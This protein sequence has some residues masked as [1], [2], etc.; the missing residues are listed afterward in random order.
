MRRLPALLVLV[1]LLLVPVGPA[2]SDVPLE[3]T[4]KVE[5][6]ELPLRAHMVWLADPVLQRTALVDVDDGHLLGMLSTGFGMPSPL[7]STARP[8]IYLPETYYSRG[9]RGERTDVLTVYAAE[10][11]APLGEVVLPPKRAI[12]A[13]PVAHATLLDDQRFA[14]VWNATPATSVSV[15]DV[16]ERHLVGELQTPGCSLVYSVGPRRFAMLCMDGSLLLV[17][18]DESGAESARSRSEPFFDPTADPVTEKAVRIGSRWL[19]VSFEGMLYDVD[20]AGDTPHVGEP[21]SM[22]SDEERA[23]RWRIGGTQHLAV[24]R[25]SG[26]LYSL[27][28]QGGPDSHKDPGSEVWVYDLAS[29]RRV[30][31]IEMRN[32]GLTYMGVPL[33]TGGSF[34]WLVDWIAERIFRAVPELGIDAIAVTQDDAPRLVTIARFTGG[35][36]TFDATDGEFLGRVYGGN[37]TNTAIAAPYGWSRP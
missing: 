21:W 31:R 32:P 13:T 28:H 30:Q 2:R 34:A 1:T 6:L 5:R 3:K 29:R 18:L 16:W 4:G 33:Q 7:F 23:E 26:R 15:V 22:F 36:A 17:T 24:H 27:V 20:F 8:E 37:M 11:L 14:V 35:I 12:T 19:F 25:D 10:T 9:T